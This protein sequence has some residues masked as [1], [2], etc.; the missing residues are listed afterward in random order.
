MVHWSIKRQE[1]FVGAPQQWDESPSP[2]FQPPVP[3]AL[4]RIHLIPAHAVLR[5]RSRPLESKCSLVLLQVSES[6][7]D[8]YFQFDLLVLIN[9]LKLWLFHSSSLGQGKRTDKWRS[10]KK[11]E[12]LIRE[13]MWW[14][15]LVR[16][17]LQHH[18]RDVFLGL[19]YPQLPSLSSL[20]VLHPIAS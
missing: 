20:K 8:C 7:F 3:T 9:H 5:G 19:S 13:P 14:G 6:K 15:G 11:P 17:N 16:R 2:P 1:S 18:L 12:E 10:L 4:H